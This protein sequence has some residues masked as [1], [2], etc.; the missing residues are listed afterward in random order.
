MTF[1][2]EM[3]AELGKGAVVKMLAGLVKMIEVRV[4]IGQELV[5]YDLGMDYELISWHGYD[6]SHELLLI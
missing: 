6:S 2:I 3:L 4:G 5:Y 1:A